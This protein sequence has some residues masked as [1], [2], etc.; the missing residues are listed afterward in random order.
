M[1]LLS[2]VGRRAM[3]GKT[4]AGIGA[5][6]AVGLGVSDTVGPTAA[7][8]M[9]EIGLGDPEADQYFLGGDSSFRYLAG[10]LMGGTLGGAMRA[11]AP[12]DY[13]R[14]NPYSPTTGVV[15]GGS[16]LG[17]GVGALAGAALA[18]PIGKGIRSG[19]T[20]LSEAAADNYPNI[21][22]S[23]SEMAQG[24]SN[25]SKGRRAIIGGIAGLVGA[26]AGISAGI[27]A[28][29]AAPVASHLSQNREFM[30]QSPYSTSRSTAVNLNASGNIVL[31]MHNSRRGY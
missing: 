19:L 5:L 24:L 9:M 11:S 6:T 21:S 10:T 8:A 15:M 20:N 29:G 12:G 30:S 26:S 14:E 1:S 28:T 31:G 25:M 3:P 18:K 4:L 23:A 13:I 16:A 2:K 27:G 22:S 17:L 7:D